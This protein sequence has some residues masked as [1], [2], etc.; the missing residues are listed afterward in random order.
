MLNYL[1]NL[2]WPKLAKITII[3]VII[4][5]ALV[6]GFCLFK[7]QTFNYNALDLAIF[8]QV[9]YNSSLGDL[10]EFT[11]H[12][13]SYLGDHF[14]PIILLLLPFYSLLPHPLSLL[15]L[16]TFFIA[17]ATIPLFLIAKKHLS[18]L[19]TLLIIVLYL[20]NPATLNMNLYEFHLLA[21]LPFFIFWTFYFYQNNNFKAFLA[22]AGLSLLIREDVA[23]VIFMFGLVAV[24]DKK[25]FKW[26]LT[27]LILSSLYFFTAL[28]I[29]A[30]FASSKD[31]KFLIYYQWLGNNLYEIFI[32]FFLKFN[33]V[34]ERV[35]NI[36]FFELILGLFFIFLFLPI[37]RPK[38]LLLSLG[39]FMQIILA[40]YS[41]ESIL[42]SH[43]AAIFLITFSL[44]AI[45]S[46]KYLLTNQKFISLYKKYK[47]VILTIL[48]IGLIYNFLILGP[49]IPLIKAVITTDYQQ[50]T[51]KKEF[52]K[53]IPAQSSVITTYDLITS[54]SSR[55]QIYSLNYT[56]LNQ[57]Q[58]EQGQYQIP[59]DTQY[60]LI[61]FNDFISYKF[62][63]KQRYTN[64]YYQGDNTLRAL[65]KTNNYQLKKAK[66]NLALWQKNI[67]S[68][69][70]LYKIY[71]QL[72]E[73]KN[74][75]NQSIDQQIEFLGYNSNNNRISLYFKS[76]K[77]ISKN[78]FIEMNQQIYPLGYGLYPTSEWRT[79]QIIQM[80]F[81]NPGKF[82][83]FQI[84]DIQ[85]GVEQNNI[86]SITNIFD[87]IQVLAEISLN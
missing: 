2:T 9:F 39:M 70:T 31:Y 1:Q 35:I 81:Y 52:I 26:I 30:D 77:P 37:F 50:V 48:I 17:L 68:N 76:L 54:L 66:Q 11:I 57:Q 74:Q 38:Y 27:P 85:G 29:S 36:H 46:L 45:F 51:L 3:L 73:I 64:N 53:Q 22:L 12:P 75:Q 15:F 44:A 7:Y 56:F 60:L 86:C 34:L 24:L 5:I 79:D 6:F 16:Q 87:Q 72:P 23:F 84:I 10:F 82:N 58:Y 25:K 69:L 43:Y 14:T 41:G 21:F 13:T 20:F 32:N 78:Y 28:K 40:R 4:Y 67:D 18:R 59:K 19:P 80:N 33:L 61:N 49:L 65:I 8:N 47:T 83:K 42:Q 62:Q 63:Y 71:D 55:Q